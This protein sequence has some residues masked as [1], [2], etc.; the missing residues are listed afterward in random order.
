M[1]YFNTSPAFFAANPFVSDFFAPFTSRRIAFH[2]FTPF[3]NSFLNDFPSPHPVTSRGTLLLTTTID[4]CSERLQKTSLKIQSTHPFVYCKISWQGRAENGNFRE[5]FNEKLDDREKSWSKNPDLLS[6]ISNARRFVN[7]AADAFEKLQNCNKR[8]K[9]VHATLLKENP[10]RST[11]GPL[12][13]ELQ[14]LAER[15]K[16]IGAKFLKR[17][18]DDSSKQFLNENLEYCVKHLEEKAT[19]LKENPKGSNEQMASLKELLKKVQLLTLPKRLTN[20]SV[21]KYSEKCQ[22]LVTECESFL[23]AHTVP[24]KIV[25]PMAEKAPVKEND[26]AAERSRIETEAPVEANKTVEE[27]PVQQNDAAAKF[28]GAEKEKPTELNKTAEVNNAVVQ[29][30]VPEKAVS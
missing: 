18:L 7:I 2:H 24:V 8:L 17:G 15:L 1:F 26:A 23:N 4:N 6:Q 20:E 12:K 25:E 3:A 13:E 11:E 14:N 16:K 28:N 21:E 29:E 10:E 27:Q 5:M 22:K 30:N 9:E 19:S